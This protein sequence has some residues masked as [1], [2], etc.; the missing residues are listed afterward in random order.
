[1]AAG[2]DGVSCFRIPSM[3]GPFPPDSDA[4]LVF[5]EARKS[6]CGDSG[7]HAMAYTKSIGR[8]SRKHAPHSH[9]HSHAANS[10][11][12]WGS[13][14]FLYNDTDPSRDGFNLGASVY[15]PSTKTVHVLFNEC[16]DK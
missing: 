7:L 16:A 1:M 13:V 8:K 10:S 12:R 11:T 5:A 3:V 4:I 15:D 14:R 2:A 6:N 9:A